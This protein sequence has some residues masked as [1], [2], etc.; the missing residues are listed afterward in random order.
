MFSTNL[1]Y[2]IK[3]LQKKKRDRYIYIVSRMDRQVS[4]GHDPI[5]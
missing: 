2:V 1:G 3:D 5:L 4:R